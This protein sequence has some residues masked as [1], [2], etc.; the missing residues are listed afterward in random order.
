MRRRSSVLPFALFV[1]AGC[2]FSASCGGKN[3]NTDKAKEFV[4][5][6]LE[7][8]VGQKPTDVTCPDKVPIEKGKSFECTASFGGP[9]ATVAMEQHDDKGGVTI[10]SITGVLV[11]SKLE[12]QIAEHFGTKLNTKLTASCG[13]RVRAATVGDKF[14]CDAT[15]ANGGKGKIAV[16]VEDTAGKV[17]FALETPEGAAPP[18]PAPEAPAPEA[19]AAPAPEA[20]PAP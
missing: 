2:Q 10:T 15:D 8:G 13:D 11:A 14:T 20:P 3:L 9:K 18:A 16:V 6:T 12:A 19:P 17:H 5:S 7:T 1:F 4:S